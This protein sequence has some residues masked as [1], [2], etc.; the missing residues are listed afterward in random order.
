MRK[1]KALNSKLLMFVIVVFLILTGSF[2]FLSLSP[3]PTI[4]EAQQIE[5]KEDTITT[6]LFIPDSLSFCGEKVP[7]QYFDV[8]ESL[9]REL[10][11]NVYFQS[12]TLGF[13]KRANRF[14][15]YIDSVLLANDIPIDFRYLPIIES[16]L[17]NATSPAGAR[18]FWQFMEATGKDYGLEINSYID[19]RYNLELAT[20]AACRYLRNSY[21]ILNNWTLVAASYNMGVNGIKRR[22]D[23]QKVNSYYD[24]DLNS[25][26]ARYV[27]RILAF[28]LIIE[29][30]KNYFIDLKKEDLYKP[31]PFELILVDTTITDLTEF[32]LSRGTN[33]KILTILNPWL[34]EN[35][36]MNKSRKE[37]VV[38]IPTPTARNIK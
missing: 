37:Y 35:T 33:Y 23:A 36:L 22:L 5:C 17:L 19:E 8:R 38:K 26:T 11:I 32:A 15:P 29:N 30:Q 20:K 34:L 6:G 2:L 16:G 27:F 21:Q 13:I 24:L 9:D 1:S 31:I 3:E 10:L 14:L 18:G 7:L 4:I 12:Q 25:E 28:K